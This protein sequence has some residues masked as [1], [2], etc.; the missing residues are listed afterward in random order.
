MV[1]QNE[2]KQYSFSNEEKEM[3]RPLPHHHSY[4]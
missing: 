3:A 2:T 4:A 1:K